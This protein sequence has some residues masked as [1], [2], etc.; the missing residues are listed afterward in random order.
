MVEQSGSFADLSLEVMLP[1]HESV[2]DE[3]RRLVT[4]LEA[5]PAATG[6]TRWN[7]FPNLM[8]RPA[9]GDDYVVYLVGSITL[10]STGV[11]WLDVE[12]HLAWDPH[13]V[14]SASV[15]VACWCSENHNQHSVHQSYWAAET[16]AALVEAFTEATAVLTRFLDS[17]R[18]DPDDLRTAAG[19]PNPRSH[20]EAGRPAQDAGSGA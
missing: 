2:L 6:R 18:T 11:D 14:V 16:D 13:R 5:H 3:L 15:N 4:E 12:L 8:D 19:L 10:F 20:A 9:G 7:W 1:G 17:T